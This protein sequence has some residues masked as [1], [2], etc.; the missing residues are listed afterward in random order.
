MRCIITVCLSANVN[1]TPFKR[2]SVSAMQIN[3]ADDKPTILVTDDDA[4][5]RM[6]TRQCLEAENSEISKL[7]HKLKSASLSI[8]FPRIAELAAEIER[9]PENVQRARLDLITSYLDTIEEK[10]G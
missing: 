7:G 9:D 8:G 4:M 6:L 5:T 10:F 1:S 2:L 3:E